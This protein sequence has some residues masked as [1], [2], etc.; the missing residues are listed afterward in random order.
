MSV[1]HSNVLKV[2]SFIATT[3]SSSSSSITSFVLATSYYRYICFSFSFIS[4]S[5]YCYFK[6]KVLL[7]LYLTFLFLLLHYFGP[8]II[9][10]CHMFAC[11]ITSNQVVSFLHNTSNPVLNNFL[12]S[13]DQASIR[14]N[15]VFVQL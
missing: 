4:T 6:Y 9:C 8:N 12:S 15:L 2:L 14:L 1:S 13:H 3:I 7:L 5:H 10:V 11:F